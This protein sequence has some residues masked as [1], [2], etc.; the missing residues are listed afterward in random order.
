MPG[1]TLGHIVFHAPDDR[2]AFVGDV[3]FPLGCGR[4]F[5]G[6]PE[7]MW[8]SLSRLLQWPDETAIWAAHEYAQSNARFALTIDDSPAMQALA[9]AI[10]ERRAQGLPTIPTQLGVERRLNPFLTASDAVTF[11]ARRAAKDQ[12]KG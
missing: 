11:A 3:L 8:D 12:F 9:L 1:H 2:L 7:Q 4:L 6:T 5:E 10:D